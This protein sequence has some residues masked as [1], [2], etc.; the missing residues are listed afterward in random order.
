PKGSALASRSS[1]NAHAAQG[2]AQE[3]CSRAVAMSTIFQQ[4]NTP[5]PAGSRRVAEERAE[6]RRRG[7][8]AMVEGWT[9]V[10]ELRP[11]RSIAGGS[12]EGLAAAIGR[13]ADLRIY[14]EF[15]FE[16]HIKPGGDGDHSH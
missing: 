6:G 3:W 10:L 14:T 5:P 15:M 16:E 7:G 2:A 8:E 13:G 4:H 12:R 9:S 11:D 1:S